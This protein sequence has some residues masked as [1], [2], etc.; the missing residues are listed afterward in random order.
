MCKSFGCNL[1][2]TL[3]RL[4]VNNSLSQK[5]VSFYALKIFIIRENLSYCAVVE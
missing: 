5:I 3:I 4:K 1:F 2:N